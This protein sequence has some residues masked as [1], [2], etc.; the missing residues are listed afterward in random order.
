MNP[1]RNSFNDLQKSAEQLKLP[2][3][4]LIACLFTFVE[5]LVG[6]NFN[7]TLYFD[8]RYIWQSHSVVFCGKIGS[9]W[10]LKIA[11]IFSKKFFW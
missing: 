2:N 5:F 10:I 1:I 8:Q 6:N 7:V 11:L 3:K 4:F 9:R